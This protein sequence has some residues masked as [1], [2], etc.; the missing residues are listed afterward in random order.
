MAGAGFLFIT[1]TT[2][3][4]TA[5]TIGIS[6][7]HNPCD[8][9]TLPML[10][11]LQN[12]Y[13]AGENINVNLLGATDMKDPAPDVLVTSRGLFYMSED[14]HPDTFKAFNFNLQDESKWN[15]AIL[16]RKD[17]EIT[18][19]GQLK[20]KII[21]IVTSASGPITP[22]VEALK[23][24]LEKNGLNPAEFNLRSATENDLHNNAADALYIKEPGLSLSLSSGRARILIE[25]PIFAKYVFSPWPMSVSA[26][27]TGLIKQRPEVA[28]KI[29]EV[30][31]RSIDFIRENP[32]KADQILTA[33]VKENFGQDGVIVRQ[34]THW[35]SSET[36]KNLIQQQ[37]QW[38]YSIGSTS[39]ELNV[40]DILY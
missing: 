29:V 6:T 16:V 30:W 1:N 12:G 21:G 25:G 17:S 8:P 5:E 37:L 39:K 33:C 9:N 3:F 24:V 26:L 35:K 15:D 10:V 34:L 2:A 31:D 27:S 18:S 7:A 19:L 4:Q 36:D 38:Y 20:G 22:K 11:A 14:Q 32:T 13:F 40:N 28:S 23:A